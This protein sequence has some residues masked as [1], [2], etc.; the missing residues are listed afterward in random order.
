MTSVP[1]DADTRIAHITL[2]DST[3]AWEIT[4][5]N[6]VRHLL[7]DQRLSLNRKN[8]TT[9]YQGLSLPAALDANL[10]NMDPPEHGRIRKLVAAA[11]TA[12]RTETLEPHIRSTCKELLAALPGQA[13]EHGVVDLIPA[14]TS[15]IPC[16][17]IADLLGVPAEDTEDFSG[18][19]TTLVNNAAADPESVK[20]AAGAIVLYLMKLIATKRSH[21]Q[22][23]LISDLIAARD[24]RDALTDDELLSLAFLLLGAGYENAANLLTNT[25]HA[26][27][28]SMD[29]AAEI[30]ESL[31]RTGTISDPLRENIIRLYDGVKHAIRRFPT[32]DI[33]VGDTIIPSGSTILLATRETNAGAQQHLS[34]G[35]GIHY[36]IGASLARME[37]TIAL[38]EFLTTYPNT[39]LA[40]DR[41]ISLR[42]S[43]R[44]HAPDTLPAVL[45]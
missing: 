21:P 6:T 4:G 41:E 39:R 2:P 14:F 13:D 25:L 12:R 35:H 31:T 11:F 20:R 18:W 26:V 7:A 38:E 44:V 30:T 3:T 37:L 29:L 10:L 28:T 32:T 24:N 8:S 45:S 22:D 33:A 27:L 5:Y 9:G 43:T 16:L 1:V 15:V 34:F 42:P 36:C 23:D 40:P 17:A 19:T